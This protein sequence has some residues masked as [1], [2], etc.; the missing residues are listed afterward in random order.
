MQP[1]SHRVL[2]KPGVRANLS[3]Q[4][5]RRPFG[6]TPR[7]LTRAAGMTV[8][9]CQEIG[10]GSEIHEDVVGKAGTQR[11]R[12]HSACVAYANANPCLG[13]G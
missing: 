4:Q 10:E 11:I 13:S 12:D 2:F 7:T 3:I 8:G 6:G 9:D 1:G 5:Q